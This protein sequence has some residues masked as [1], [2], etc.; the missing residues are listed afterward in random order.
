MASGRMQV[1]PFH[2]RRGRKT[3]AAREEIVS[4][5]WLRPPKA[6]LDIRSWPPTMEG[7]SQKAK[8]RK[9]PPRIL[10]GG[11]QVGSAILVLSNGGVNKSSFADKNGSQGLGPRGAGKGRHH[12][13]A[14]GGPLVRA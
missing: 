8:R 5:T 2:E 7:L 6:R 4:A 11:R 3:L 12:D 1:D 10:S 13:L 14:G 9:A